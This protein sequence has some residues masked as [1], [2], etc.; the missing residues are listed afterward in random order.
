MPSPAPSACS[1][2]PF[3]WPVRTGRRSASRCAG[4]ACCRSPT[5]S[6]APASARRRVGGRVAVAMGRS[7]A[8]LSSTRSIHGSFEYA[9]SKLEIWI[10][11]GAVRV[12][13]DDERH[14][15]VCEPAV[16]GDS[17]H[18]FSA[19]PTT[20][21]SPTRKSRSSS[22]RTRRREDHDPDLRASTAPT[23]TSRGC[24]A[25][26]RALRSRCPPDA[27]TRREPAR[28]RRRPTRRRFPRHWRRRKY[29][30]SPQLEA[31]RRSLRLGQR[32]GRVDKLRPW[33]RSPRHR[34]G[35][36]TV[37]PSTRSRGRGCPRRV[38][39]RPGR[40]LLPWPTNDVIR[41]LGEYLDEAP[42][43]DKY[44]CSSA[45]GP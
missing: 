16:V 1:T 44:S 32:G 14:F 10:V 13:G 17:E 22:P 37:V 41:A 24:S 9:P 8:G 43:S 26:S 3:R 38:G 6:V 25:S 42:A 36:C 29:A 30:L 2:R 31:L 20:A 40:P 7:I 33:R 28:P 15:L 45:T 23:R 21:A 35:P 12:L 4:R 34:P 11:P 5:A 27:R 18:T 19:P 39:E